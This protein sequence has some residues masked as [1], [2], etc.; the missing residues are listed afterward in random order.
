MHR[1]LRADTVAEPHGHRTEPKPDALAVT[2]TD[3]AEPVT[4]HHN[5]ATHHPTTDARRLPGGWHQRAR[6]R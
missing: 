3:H 6:R 1:R 2:H 4:D 5:P